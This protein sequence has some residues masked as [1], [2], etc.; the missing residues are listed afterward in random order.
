MK[1]KRLW[2]TIWRILNSPITLLIL[3]LAFGN[4]YL[5][6]ILSEAQY[7]YQQKV[8]ESDARYEYS[9]SLLNLSYNNFYQA[10]NYYWNYSLEPDFKERKD[11]LWN[12]YQ[13]A[14]EE[15]NVKLV[16][17]LFALDRY[18]GFTLRKYFED[19]IQMNLNSLHKELL[20]IRDN[21]PVDVQLIE[22]LIS[23]L[24]NRLYVLVEKLNNYP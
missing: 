5:P 22:N 4:Y 10:R 23:I 12:K 9:A 21:E 1:R 13:K 24:E 8:K 17:N 11:D 16:T 14:V 18:H 3:T 6:R 7:S 2:E 15:W 19:E 20:H